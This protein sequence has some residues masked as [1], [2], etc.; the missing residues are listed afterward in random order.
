MKNVLIVT[1][2]F[3]KNNRSLL[4]VVRRKGRGE[5]NNVDR[6]RVRDLIARKSSVF[7]DQTGDNDQ[8]YF[9]RPGLYPGRFVDA[10]RHSIPSGAG[11]TKNFMSSNSAFEAVVLRVFIPENPYSM[12][13]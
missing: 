10:F 1:H 8:S 11:G 12:F 7:A 2:A 5:N 3:N 4:F 9:I 13:C 6:K